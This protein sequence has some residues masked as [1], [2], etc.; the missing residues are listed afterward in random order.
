MNGYLISDVKIT[1]KDFLGNEHD[2]VYDW[3][4]KFVPTSIVTTQAELIAGL[5]AKAQECVNCEFEYT[6]DSCYE[7]D[8][9]SDVDDVSSGVNG[10]DDDVSEDVD[11]VSGDISGGVSGDTNK[12]TD[13]KKL[14]CEMCVGDGKFNSDDG[15][16]WF[17][18]KSC[19]NVYFC[20]N[21]MCVVH[22]IND[23]KFSLLY[24][25]RS[26]HDILCGIKDLISGSNIKSAAKSPT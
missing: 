1:S 11:D 15:L 16:W 3:R 12:H 13:K 8:V 23:G 26:V 6:C 4:F 17:Y 14:D 9:C 25:F 21:H 22:V 24:S 2:A 5:I 19:G 7:I 18:S 20:P 10:V